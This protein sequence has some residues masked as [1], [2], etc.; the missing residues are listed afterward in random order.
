MVIE[1]GQPFRINTE[2]LLLRSFV[3]EDATAAF[4]HPGHDGTI[5]PA[6]TVH[7]LALANLHNEFATVLTTEAVLT[8]L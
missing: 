1:S 5:Y 2:A 4:D 7:A 3:V 8:Q 6:E